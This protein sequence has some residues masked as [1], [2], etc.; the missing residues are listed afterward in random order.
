[1]VALASVD[2]NLLVA[3]RALLRHC[4]VTRAAAEAGVSQPAMSSNLRRLRRI[5][6][7]DLL[8]RE[9]GRASC[10]ERVFALV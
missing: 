8:I 5:L 3:L 4:N 9:I 2:L 7:D 10:R 6:G 1:M